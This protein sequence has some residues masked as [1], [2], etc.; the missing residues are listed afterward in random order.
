MKGEKL[1]RPK[2]K[3]KM[4]VRSFTVEREMFEAVESY[5]AEHGT[6]VSWVI[7]QALKM[8][9]PLKYFTNEKGLIRERK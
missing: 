8:F 4:L 1:G 6:N 9:V 7:R 3:E 5:A 2:A